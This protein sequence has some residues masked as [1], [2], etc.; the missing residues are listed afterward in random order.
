L[1]AQNSILSVENL[2]VGYAKKEGWIPFL[3]HIDLSISDGGSLGIVGESGSGKSLLCYSLM[4]LLEFH[5]AKVLGGRILFKDKDLLELSEDKMREH[6]GRDLGMIFQ[7]PMSS[8]NPVLTIGYQVAEV[9]RLHKGMS[10]KEAWQY[11]TDLLAQ[12]GILKPEVRIRDYPHQLSGGQRQRVMIAIA[13]A[14]KPQLIIADEPTTALDVTIQKQI[15]ELLLQ[16]REVSGTSLLFVSHDLALVKQ[17]SDSVCVMK[18]G[19]IVESGTSSQIFSDPEHKYS[20]ALVGCRISEARKGQP[21]PIISDFMTGA[22]TNSPTMKCQEPA[23]AS[24]SEP[25]AGEVLVEILE[26]S[27][28]FPGRRNFWGRFSEGTQALQNVSLKILNN[29]VLGLVGESGSGKTT[30]GRIL[31]RLDQP[32]RGKVTYREQD[33]HGMDDKELFQFRRR[34]QVI[35]QDPLSSL[36]PRH[37]VRDTLLEALKI[38]GLHRGREQRR[39][40]E[41]I[42]LVGLPKNFRTKYPHALSGGERQRVCI[43]RALAVEPEFLVCD[44]PVSSLDASIRGQI[45]NLLNDLK[46]ELKLTYLFISHDLEVVKYFCDEVAVMKDGQIVEQGAAESVFAHPRHDYTKTLIEAI[47]Q[48]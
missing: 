9:L 11:S 12:V 7:E 14:C 40:E 23:L 3:K 2:S 22:I 19:Q 10:K 35:F 27:K 45:L 25:V 34:V 33:I 31:L 37:S 39:I 8:L 48:W 38:H 5:N 29:Q 16:L 13:M 41:L 21:L 36:N 24:K 42:D 44:E 43:A 46:R 28:K 18:D 32:D 6:R 30:L 20:K 17:M 47:P 4:R 26:L 15:L 1:K